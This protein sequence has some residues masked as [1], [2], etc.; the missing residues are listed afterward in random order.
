[1]KHKKFLIGI[2]LV[3][4]LLLGYFGLF[5]G[6]NEITSDFPNYYVSGKMVRLDDS[7]MCLYDTSCFKKAI[8]KEGIHAAGQ[9]ALYPPAN[10]L[11]MVPLTFFAPLTAK[12]IWLATELILLIL[13][14]ILSAS[15][16]N[17][18][19][20]QSATVVLSAGFALFNDLYLGQIYIFLLF[21]FISGFVLFEKQKFLSSGM[22]WSILLSLKYISI[23]VL[24]WLLLKFKWKN[25]WVIA[26]GFLAI[27]GICYIAMGGEVLE[28]YYADIFTAHLTGSL[29]EGKPVSVNYQSWESLLIALFPDHSICRLTGKGVFY[30]LSFLY[31]AAL[32][33]T[34]QHNKNFFRTMFSASLIILLILDPGSATYHLVFLIFPVL[35]ILNQLLARGEIFHVFFLLL[36]FLAIG[37]FPLAYSKFH[38]Y[39]SGN[40]VIAYA[41]LLLLTAF[42]IYALCL[43]FSKNTINETV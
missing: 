34:N 31:L 37:W 7:L 36:M 15:L 16:F 29:A 35:H 14:I 12:R 21:L 18:S 23:V 17:L 28:K 24:P 1:M 39:Q 38:L 5:K 25:L 20:L 9:F 10:A 22:S 30:A 32:F 19:L 6:W 42:G 43:L 8:L 4:A 27:L 13:V 40:W 26:G 41:R 3:Q 2:V 33:Y 11:V